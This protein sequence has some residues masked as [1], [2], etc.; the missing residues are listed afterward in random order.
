MTKQDLQNELKAAML[1]KN[2]GKKSTL[3]MLISAIGYYEIQKGGAG[4]EATD[5]DIL[6]VIQKEAKQR[7]D[8]I[9]QYNDGGRPELAAKEEKELKLLETYLPAQMGEEEIRILVKEAISTTGA[10]SVQDM[11]K[12]MGALMPKVKGKA[13]GSLVNKIVKEELAA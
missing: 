6:A 13:D 10:S 12:I 4:Y 11:G 9:T 2:E 3:R 5:E 1:A 8:A 7:K